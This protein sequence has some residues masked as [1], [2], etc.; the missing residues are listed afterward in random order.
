[1]VKNKRR[2][3]TQ[4]DAAPRPCCIRFASGV[5]TRWEPISTQSIEKRVSG[6]IPACAETLCRF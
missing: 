4:R 3:A 2:E 1:M 5:K 6:P